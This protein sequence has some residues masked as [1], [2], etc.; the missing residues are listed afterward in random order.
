M[1]DGV[2]PGHG[3][4]DGADDPDPDAHL[5][6]DDTS[7]WVTADRMADAWVRDTYPG[8][9]QTPPARPDERDLVSVWSKLAGE[10]LWALARMRSLPYPRFGA[11]LI[12]GNVGDAHAALEEMADR[13]DVARKFAWEEEHERLPED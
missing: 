6:E 11:I 3:E 2:P 7:D 13:I 10:A 5:T 8:L 9:S 12:E 1:M 4:P